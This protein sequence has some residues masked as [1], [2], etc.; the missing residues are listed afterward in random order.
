MDAIEKYLPLAG[1]IGMAWLFIPAGWSKV[2]GLA[3]TAAYVGSKGLPFPT[4]LAAIALAIELLA[5][6]AVLVGYKTRWAAALLALFTIAAAVFFHNYWAL[7]ADQQMMQ[8]INFDKNIAIA[9]GLLFLV[10]WGA[11]A[12]SLDG[13]KGRDVARAY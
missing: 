4:V 5:G 6:L 9:G 3:G 8:K 12:L 1:R 7:P 2:G 10:A 13:N 11:G